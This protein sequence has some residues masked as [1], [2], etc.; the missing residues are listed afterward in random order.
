HPNYKCHNLEER[1]LVALLIALF[2]Q[3][4][5]K[6]FRRPVSALAK[7]CD[8]R[9][10]QDPRYLHGVLEPLRETSGIRDIF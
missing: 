4:I 2:L 8:N 3:M 6:R 9:S 7:Q 10:S 5:W 1:R